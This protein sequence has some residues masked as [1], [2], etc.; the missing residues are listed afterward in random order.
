MIDV[1]LSQV[2]RSLEMSQIQVRERI[3]FLRLGKSL[4]KDEV[5]CKDNMLILYHT[6]HAELY[7]DLAAMEIKDQEIAVACVEVSRFYAGIKDSIV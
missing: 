2:R 3:D 6:W 5:L 1:L 7:K 4:I